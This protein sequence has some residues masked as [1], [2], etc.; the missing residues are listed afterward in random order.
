MVS[1]IGGISV[2]C[3]FKST[4]GKIGTNNRGRNTFDVKDYSLFIENFQDCINIGEIENSKT[5]KNKGVL[6]LKEKFGEKVCA[7][8]P[9]NAYFDKKNNC[10]LV[11][12]TLDKKT[13]NS[14][15]GGTPC[16]IFDD[17]GNILAIWHGK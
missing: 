11:R 10:W 5:A 3:Y 16:V 1:I 17:N 13:S 12:G 9:Y 8:E 6:F 7:Y 4:I 2:F 15:K 14:I